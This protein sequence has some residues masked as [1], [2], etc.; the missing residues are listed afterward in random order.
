[1]FFVFS[2]QALHITYVFVA[3]ECQW[4]TLSN[5]YCL[6]WNLKIESLYCLFLI[7]FIICFVAFAN[8]IINTSS[9][10]NSVESTTSALQQRIARHEE[11]CDQSRQ[12]CIYSC[13]EIGSSVSAE[14]VP[15][16]DFL[17]MHF[18][19]HLS[20]FLERLDL[21]LIS[22]FQFTGLLI[23]GMP[24]FDPIYLKLNLECYFAPTWE[25]WWW[26]R[27]YSNESYDRCNTMM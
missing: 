22:G 26:L 24:R 6:L 9:N 5:I 4:Y 20:P 12:Q 17:W 16:Y 19:F 21:Q 11:I 25:A 13:A 10:L 1:M 2:P 23:I 14:N 3:Y 27:I 18:C 15:A 8:H 7:F